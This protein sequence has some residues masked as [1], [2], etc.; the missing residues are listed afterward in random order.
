MQAY[1]FSEEHE[2]F[3]EG[4][5][6][7]LAQ[8]VHPHINAWEQAGEIPK[9]IWKK[10]GQ[11]G[12]LGL[13]YPEAYGGSD[14]DFF[15]TVAY[16]EELAWLNSGGFNAAAGVTPYMAGAH[17]LA[18]ASEALKQKYLP[19]SI[20]GYLLGALAIT[21]PVA[22]SDVSNIRT[23]AVREGD[24]YVVNGSKTFITNGYLCDY[25]VAAV[26]TKHEAGA[27]GISL[28]LIDKR[29]SDG[30]RANKLNKLGW[31]SSDTAEIFFDNVRVPV[32][33]LIGEEN[34]GF[35]YIMNKFQLERLIM[36]I[37]GVA[38]AEVA[39][40]TALKYMAEREAFGRPINKFQ[41]LRHRIADLYAEL[42]STRYFVY[43][44]ARLHNDGHYD[45]KLASIAKLKGTELADRATYECLQYFGGY[46]FMED[47][48]LARM[49]R[50]SRIGTIGGGSS[51]IMREIIAKTLIDSVKYGHESQNNTPTSDTAI[52]AR[53]II[54][55]LPQRFKP[56]KAAAYE[57][58]FHFD[59]SGT[60]GGQYTVRLAAGD[61]QVSVGFQGTP[62]CVVE[63]SAEVYA[64]VETGQMD[65][66]QAFMGGKI[67]ASNPMEMLTFGS[68]FKR[69]K[70]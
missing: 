49:F 22:G 8:E 36:A 51:E 43:H 25:I 39:L 24:H 30:V 31:H 15:Y 66:Q 46:G 67:K 54:A 6:R 7:F 68:F 48:P 13:N 27:A 57:G 18:A 28:L 10:F 62:T 33:N 59:L 29:E 52:T 53:E 50:D 60:G 17:I 16:I 64:A 21:E 55:G 11:M 5:R 2:L 12:Y 63:T 44:V 20:S 37:G 58:V 34:Q 47:Y 41:A 35:Y 19:G 1:Y 32:S 26:K 56:E 4:L 9:D 70:K 38:A 40:Q 42:E 65:P 69:L 3:R 14:A 23:T 61:C 45:V